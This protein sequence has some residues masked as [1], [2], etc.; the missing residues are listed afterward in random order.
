ME[1]CADTE[2]EVTLE[3]LRSVTSELL[4]NRKSLKIPED[5][6]YFDQKFADQMGWS[7]EQIKEMGFE[8]AP[9]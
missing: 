1:D 4:K 9:E 3:E 6:L 2:Q 5:L 8:Q 7:D